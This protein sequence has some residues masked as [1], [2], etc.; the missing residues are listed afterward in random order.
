MNIVYYSMTGQTQALINKIKKK[1]ND[2]IFFEI[3]ELT[4]NDE[5]DFDFILIVPSYDKEFT[6]LV[7]DFLDFNSNHMQGVIGGGNRNF[8]DK[9]CMTA[10]DISKVYNTP[11][12][13]SYEFRG[14]DVDVDNIIN[15]L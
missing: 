8:G 9:F 4:V 6:E 12:L 2:I 13:Y 14:L 15:L 5:L 11:F 7:Y 10:K 3:T 1:K